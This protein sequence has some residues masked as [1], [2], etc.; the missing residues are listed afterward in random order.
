MMKFQETINVAKAKYLLNLSD[1]Y[2]ISNIFNDDEQDEDGK[3]YTTEEYIKNCKKWLKHVIKN[4][5]N[6]RSDYKYSKFM[7]DKGRIYVKKFGIQSLQRDLRGFLCSEFYVD[8]DMINAHNQILFYLRNKFFPDEKVDNLK[9]YINN[10]NKVLNHFNTNKIEILKLLNSEWKYKGPNKFLQAIDIEFKNLQ[11]LIWESDN[12]IDV[13]KQSL[14]AK[15]KKGSFINRVLCVYENLI[16]QDAIKKIGGDVPMFDGF[17]KRK[18]EDINTKDIIEKLNNNEYGIKWSI[19]PHSDKIKIDE[20]LIITEYEDEYT[21]MKKEF[22]KKFFMVKNPKIYC[23]LDGEELLFYKKNDFIDIVAPWKYNDDGKK[24]SFF[25]DWVED[26]DRRIYKK[27]DFIPDV[28]NCPDDVY[29]L[30]KPFKSEYIEKDERID[31]SLFYELIDLL[32]DK[33]EDCKN[34]LLC[35]IADLFQNTINCPKTGILFKGV[36]G[37]GKDMMINFINNIMGHNYTLAVSDLEEILG[38]F[39]SGISKKLLLNISELD[40][41]DASNFDNKIKKFIVDDEHKVELK[42]FDAKYETNYKRI[43]ATS[44]ND[45]PLKLS[46]KNRRWTVFL[47]GMPREKEFYSKLGGHLKDQ[48]FLNSLYSEFMDYNINMDVTKPFET[49]E[50]LEMQELNANPFY[51]F[52]YEMFKQKEI[53]NYDCYQDKKDKNIVYLRNDHLKIYFDSWLDENPDY[54]ENYKE[55]VN[56]RKLKLLLGKIKIDQI[57]KKLGDKKYRVYPINLNNKF[58]ELKSLY[59]WEKYAPVLVE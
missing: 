20:S 26:E 50:M 29:N 7:I 31:T 53:L 1:D 13:P 27:M 33:R 30:F 6:I 36:E 3:E 51:I 49:K 19:K 48:Y 58:E 11:K 17:F 45:V 25:K 57:A 9:N 21:K 12:F 32:T 24:K 2:W 38:K 43:F 52:C 22:E 56:Y 23:E 44:N 28:N 37:V 40:G 5:G 10:R 16:L 47:T 46:T 18:T 14:K 4:N 41:R 42:G 55:K 54:S 8:I 34:Y 39:T 59:D 15:N 35:Y